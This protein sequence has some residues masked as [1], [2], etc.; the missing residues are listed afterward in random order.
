MRWPGLR[1]WHTL[2]LEKSKQNCEPVKEKYCGIVERTDTV[3]DTN[4]SNVFV[5]TY[6][7]LLSKHAPI[8]WQ[9][10][11]SALSLID[12][13]NARKYIAWSLLACIALYMSINFLITNIEFQVAIAILLADLLRK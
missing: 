4:P 11:T 10:P 6:F 13:S 7:Y 2:V 12:T 3:I 9:A 1:L 8:K 5:G